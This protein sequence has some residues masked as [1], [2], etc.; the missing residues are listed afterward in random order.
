MCDC[1]R[2]VAGHSC[3]SAWCVARAKRPLVLSFEGW[4]MRKLAA[5]WW[6][7][8]KTLAELRASLLRKARRWRRQVLRYL[9]PAGRRHPYLPSLEMLEPRRVFTTVGFN[10][11][12]YSA[13][14]HDA[15]GLIT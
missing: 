2:R 7:L 3:C 13:A 5:R 12:S 11:A 8:G 14:H 6:R 9:W 1:F 10:G 15:S 4:R